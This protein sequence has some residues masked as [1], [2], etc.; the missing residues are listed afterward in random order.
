MS[1]EAQVWTLEGWDVAARSVQKPGENTKVIEL[2][3]V[4]D[5]LERF[6]DLPE[7]CAQVPSQRQRLRDEVATLLYAHRGRK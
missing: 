3:P 7:N 4:L 5:L 2:E 1:V 6:R